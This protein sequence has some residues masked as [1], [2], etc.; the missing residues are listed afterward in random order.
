MAASSAPGRFF[1]KR[2]DRADAGLAGADA[3]GLVEVV[4]KDLAV[5]DLAGFGSAGNHIDYL[6]DRPG[7]DSEF[8][9]QLRQEA[10]RGFRSAVAIG[11]AAWRGGGVGGG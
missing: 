7:I 1:S 5:A 9:F 2:S 6:V 4:D 11:G 10:D 3:H 8:D